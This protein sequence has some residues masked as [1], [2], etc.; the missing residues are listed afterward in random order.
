MAHLGGQPLDRAGDDAERAEECGMA[1]TRDDLGGD[2]FGRSAR[3]SPPRIPP[4][5]GPGAAK[6]PTAPLI[7][8]TATSSR[9][10]ASRRVPVAGEFG[11]VAGQFQ[12][13][14]GR[15][16]VDAV[17]A[18]DGQR[19]FVLHRPGLQR[20]HDRVDV[21]QQDVGGLGQLHRQRGVQHVGAGHALVH[22]AESGPT[23]SASQVRKAM[24]SW[25]VSR[26]IASIRSTSAAFMAASFGPPFSRMVRAAIPGMA[27]T[28]P[29]PRRPGLPLRTRF[30]SGSR[31]PDGGHFG[32]GIT[33]NHR[34]LVRSSRKGQLDQAS[35]KASMDWTQDLVALAQVVMI[36]VALAGDNAVVVGLAVRRAAVRGNSGRRSCWG[37]RG[38]T[39]IRI[40]WARWRCSCWS[41][42]G[43]CSPAASCCCGFAGG[44][45]VSCGDL[46]TPSLSGVERR[47]GRR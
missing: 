7:A 47:C 24:T 20:R 16:G 26:S 2:R 19:V 3:V 43:C 27:P 4:R 30:D 21:L 34:C 13:E 5:A 42:S 33:R 8:T 39:V 32:S 31:R 12:P 25:R 35:R 41:S 22:E 23:A 17:A 1:I 38:A 44:C 45:F 10:A 29:C 6:V 9:A 11:V 14:C 15:F 37:L 28:A 40:G 18:A 36:D 46:V